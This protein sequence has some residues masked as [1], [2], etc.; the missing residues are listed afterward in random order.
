MDDSDSDSSGD[1]DFANLDLTGVDFDSSNDSPAL[2]PEDKVALEVETYFLKGD[3]QAASEKIKSL[4]DSHRL[5]EI[6]SLVID[7]KY[8]EALSGETAKWLFAR[9][10][11]T[12]Q[13]LDFRMILSDITSIRECV[14]VEFFAIA[15]F[16]LFLQ[17][18][19]TG[20]A[21]DESS[22]LQDINPHPYFHQKL[23]FSQEEEDSNQNSI[24]HRRSTKY[25]NF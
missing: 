12:S 4:K 20:P 8:V 21:I 16:N 11:N 10:P 7:G 6:V 24:T 18:N 19:Y 5:A 9:S 25:H 23:N 14:E 17:L 3:F 2:H 15:A 13:D 1:F 22:V